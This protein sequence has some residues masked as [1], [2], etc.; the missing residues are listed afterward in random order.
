MRTTAVIL[1]ALLLLAG[2]VKEMS[3]ESGGSG[4]PTPIPSTGDTNFLDKI[5]LLADPVGRK[6][7]QAVISFTY[8]VLK[9]VTAVTTSSPDNTSF[10]E[11]RQ[12]FYS[13]T[14][15]MPYKY[16]DVTRY[17]APQP[18]QLLDSAIRYFYYN[19]AGQKIKDSADD[20]N[21]SGGSLS[22]TQYIAAYDN[23]T[24]AIIA[25]ITIRDVTGGG[26][27]N[28]LK[29]TLLL[30]AKNNITRSKLYQYDPGTAAYT[31]TADIKMET[32][33][34]LN[35]FYRLNTK[36]AERSYLLGD[37][38]QTDYIQFNNIAKVTTQ[39]FM[40]GV[41]STPYDYY[42]INQL[43]NAAGYLWEHTAHDPNS[44]GSDILYLFRYKKR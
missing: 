11:V 28:K 36:T 2:C 5:Y 15:T 26:S 38:H 18:L 39:H 7:T 33:N 44:P 21:Y 43:P 24:S 34:Y 37:P 16:V 27:D 14:D 22:R 20:F 13:G 23:G 3:N 35:P 40:L 41:P 31:A 6:D 4:V 25:N 42:Y 17:I 1:S 12:Y 8:D 32:D 9:R 19:T 30:D 10:L 29:D